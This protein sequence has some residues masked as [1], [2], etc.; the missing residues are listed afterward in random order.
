MCAAALGRG[1]P[2]MPEEAL[3]EREHLRTGASANG[4]THDD[5][6]AGSTS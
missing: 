4:V 6:P 2:T 5:P 3:A 1:N